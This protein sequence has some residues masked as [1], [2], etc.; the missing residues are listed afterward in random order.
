MDVTKLAF[1]IAVNSGMV[2]AAIAPTE[3][4]LI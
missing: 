4:K 2:A 3:L 1:A